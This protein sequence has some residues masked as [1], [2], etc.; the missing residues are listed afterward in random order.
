MSER[1]MSNKRIRKNFGK[2]RKIVEIPDLIGMQ[3]ESFSRFLQIDVPVEKRRDIGIVQFGFAAFGQR[4]VIPQHEGF[5]QRSV[6]GIPHKLEQH[7]VGQVRRG[8]QQIAGCPE[9]IPRR[10]RFHFVE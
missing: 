8:I 4:G 2:I 3:R 6:D 10:E 5:C 9:I 1:L 7:R